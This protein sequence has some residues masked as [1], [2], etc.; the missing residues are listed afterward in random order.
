[1]DSIALMIDTLYKNNN[2]VVLDL[3]TTG[4][5]Y[6]KGDRLT[7]VCG[8]SIENGVMSKMFQ[9][10]VNPEQP[11]PK[12]ITEITGIDDKM[13][14]FSPRFYDIAQGLVDFIGDKPIVCHNAE[15]DL[16]KFLV[17]MYKDIGYK[18]PNRNIC[19]LQ[20]ARLFM[21]NL[22]SKKLG[23]VYKVLTGKKPVNS[24]RALGDVGMTCEV[25]LK[26]KDFVTRNYDK[27]ISN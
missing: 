18:I 23:E 27:I 3:E 26:F 6:Y 22:K 19:T 16:D 17:P 1:M 10:L 2:F 14:R 4:F 7:E 5:S 24:H 21:S 20:L 15:F 9:T 12:H 13:V 8:Y 25:L 11:I